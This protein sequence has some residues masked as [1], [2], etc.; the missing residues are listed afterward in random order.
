MPKR[1]VCLLGLLGMFSFS[2]CASLFNWSANPRI[3][4]ST[5]TPD[6]LVVIRNAGEEV[7]K[8]YTPYEITLHSSRYGFLPSHYE[9]VFE[10]EGYVTETHYRDG[11]FCYWYIGN[12]LLGGLIGMLI[13]D[14][15]TGS[16]YKIDDYPVRVHMRRA[17]GESVEQTKQSGQSQFTV[18]SMD[19]NEK[20]H[21]GL[22]KIQ[23]PQEEYEGARK[24][25][26]RS[27]ETLAKDKNVLLQT[28]VAPS[29]ARYYIGAETIPEPGVL[30]VAFEV[31]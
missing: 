6:A 31:E 23:Y 28:G 9:F 1:I 19:Y 8:F 29:E 11:K 26:R 15:L 25:V 30:Q 22:I 27:I 24:F 17:D 5:D 7:G 20:T 4:I 21:K 13:V 3:A 14:P 12:V 16:M 2:G 10:K 18:L